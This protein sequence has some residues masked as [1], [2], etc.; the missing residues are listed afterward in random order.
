MIRVNRRYRL[1]LI[2]GND[3]LSI[4]D[5]FRLS[6]KASE[7]VN[8]ARTGLNQLELQI[9]NLSPNNRLKFVQDETTRKYKKVVLEIGY[10][11]DL[12]IVYQGNIT[13]GEIVKNGTDIICKISCTD[14]GA[15]FLNQFIS[16]TVTTKQ[17]AIDAIL[18]A[19][20]NVQ[21]GKIEIDKDFIKPVSLYGQVGE[22]LR[23]IANED[24]DIFIRNEKLYL[25]K[26]NSITTSY[27]PLV[28][29]DTGLISVSRQNKIIEFVTLMNP[30][31]KTGALVEL[32]STVNPYLNG[33]YRV[34]AI[35]YTGDTEGNDWT[36]TCSVRNREFI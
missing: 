8:N 2:D 1:T 29:A 30:S 36:M 19:M 5:S 6:F 18:E 12:K 24:E 11:N 34:E 27:I 21:K 31:I 14:G 17:K 15:D 9:Y 26:K 32:D 4:E 25:I 28:N 13:K 16:K 20:P 33:V 7:R 22:E 23:Q 3:A 10:E 35:T